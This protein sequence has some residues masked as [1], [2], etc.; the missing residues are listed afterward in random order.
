M[1]RFTL[2]M[3][4]GVVGMNPAAHA[5]TNVW[6]SVGPDA[7][8]IQAIAVDP[9]NPDTVYAVAG[10][11][12]FKT[13]DGAANWNEIAGRNELK[14]DPT[15]QLTQS[16]GSVL[17]DP[18]NPGTLYVGIGG[19][20][21]GFLKSMDV[22]A[23]WTPITNAPAGARALAFTPGILWAGIAGSASTAVP[24]E[25]STGRASTTVWTAWM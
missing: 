21:G 22:G 8:H 16:F 17:V 5:G 23:N 24:M 19:N 10:G 2:L 9:Q 14:E 11:A 1:K 6:T 18:Q 3:L 25:V 4:Y 13:T 15:G 7:G 12:I 20:G